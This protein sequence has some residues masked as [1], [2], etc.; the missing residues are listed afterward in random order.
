M[1]KMIGFRTWAI[2]NYPS[3]DEKQFYG[4]LQKISKTLK[5]F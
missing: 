3:L 4:I 2:H 1:Q 5:N